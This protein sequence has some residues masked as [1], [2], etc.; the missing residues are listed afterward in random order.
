MRAHALTIFS[1]QDMDTRSTHDGGSRN[2]SRLPYRSKVGK[3]YYSSTKVIVIITFVALS[4][5]TCGRVV[6]RKK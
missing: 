6:Y 5:Y 2:R 4:V 3:Q 1:H